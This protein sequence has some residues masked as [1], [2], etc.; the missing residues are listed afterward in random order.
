MDIMEKSVVLWKQIIADISAIILS[1]TVFQE[2]VLDNR[3]RQLTSDIAVV[4]NLT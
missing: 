3:D 2:E 1:H 4:K